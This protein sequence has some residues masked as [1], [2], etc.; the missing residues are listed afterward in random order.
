MSLRTRMN[1]FTGWVN[2]RLNKYDMLLKNVLMDLLG[3]TNMKML[4]QSMTGIDNKKLQ[5]FDG[6]THQ[7]KAT[8]MEW[9]V[10]ELK[11]NEVLPGDI[12]VDFRL[13]AMRHAEHVFDLLWRLVSHDVWFTWERLEYLTHHEDKIL[14]EVPF[15]WTPKP[16]PEKKKKKKVSYNKSF[17]SGFGGASLISDGL[18]DSPNPFETPPESL[19]STA[20]TTPTPSPNL[21]PS[22][23]TTLPS[24]L[25]P[26]LP[27]SPTPTLPPS[28]TP[29]LPPY[30]PSSA[31]SVRSF[32]EPESPPP[33][34]IKHIRFPGE[35]FCRK[36]KKKSQHR[37][38]PEEC[39]L[40]MVTTMLNSTREGRKLNVEGLDDLVDS[41]V[42]CELV[43]SFVPGTFT[44][45]VLLNDRWTINLALKTFEKMIRI[46]TPIDSSDLLEADPMAVCC[47]MGV[48]FMCGFKIRQAKGVINRLIELEHQTRAAHH[49]LDNLPEILED[50]ELIKK[51]KMLK[52]TLEDCNQERVLIESK[53]DVE[54]CRQ[55]WKHIETVQ[56][57]TR[58][59]I[60]KKMTD[61]FDLMTLP[62]A[63]SMNDLCISLAINLTLTQGSGFYLGKT[64]E[65]VTTD[66]RIVLKDAETGDFIDDFTHGKGPSKINVRKILGMSLYEPSELNPSNYPQYEIYVESP[67]K[68]KLLKAGSIFLY[69]VFPGNYLQWENL[70]FKACKVGEYDTV[71]KLIVFFQEKKPNFINAREKKTGNMGLHMAARNGHY[72]IALFLLENGAKLDARNVSG[73]SP[74]FGAVEGLHKG[75]SQMFRI[76]DGSGKNS[77]AQEGKNSHGNTA[78]LLLE[79]GAN[80]WMKNKLGKT[81]F[82]ISKND[83]QRTELVGYYDHL[84]SCIPRLMRGDVAH[85]RRLVEDHF[86]GVQKFASLRSR[87]INGSTLIHTASYFGVVAVLKVLLKERVDVNL[88]DYKGA[89][90]LHRAK[91]KPTI[92]LLL[93]NGALL[94]A[95]DGEGN[96]PLHVKCYGEGGQPTQMDCIQQFLSENINLVHRNNKELMAIH[97]C[98]M[99]GRIDAI[100]VLLDL[101]ATKDGAIRAS[102]ENEDP[103]S[104]PSLPHLAL[105]NDFLECGEWLID[106]GFTF[107]EHEQDILVHRLLTEQ[108]KSKQRLDIMR[109][110][111]KHGADLDQ[112]YAGG[113]TPVHYAAGMTG[114]T[115]ILELLIEYGADLDSVNE[116]NCTPLFFATQS[117][118]Y[119]AASVLLNGGG[120]VRHKN[121]Q[122]LTAFDCII[123][124]DEWLECGFFTDEVK[125]RL[126]AHSLKHARDLVRAITQKVRG[127]HRKG[128]FAQVAQRSNAPNPGGENRQHSLSASLPIR[129]ALKGGGNA[130]NSNMK[131]GQGMILPPL[132]PRTFMKH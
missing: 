56:T 41:R 84:Q 80:I 101:D 67:S 71:Y 68:N 12:F 54:A 103:K 60:S 30:T 11:E 110:L 66:R 44:T 19:L 117:N 45:E 70:F 17:L 59:V 24:S 91:D 78:Q 26:T 9:I 64:R 90:P 63:V 81:A 16:P 3:G 47:A 65:T 18:P 38:D 51:R 112:R 40:E 95:I 53:F 75:I 116:D 132:K 13:F 61:R 128:L 118:N 97:C 127:S 55:W 48:Y 50:V 5:S 96:T 89:T 23:T 31:G 2:L 32:G 21:P 93:E 121:I 86:A 123:D 113:N 37:P 114:P 73:A 42:L 52:E 69:Q 129:G 131:L 39:I 83:E 98:A 25:T 49:D 8:R 82:D 85:L 126:K 14:C 108:I 107:K 130:S 106:Q 35:D 74:F 77:F 27:P 46:S 1:G 22:P 87:C 57:E 4:L 125:A 76:S 33:P 6:L 36:F 100:Q 115:D 92:R 15:E 72:D 124:F 58:E 102:L 111:F 104:P 28:P 120:N 94:N 29:T 34:E 10:K 99:Q 88:R 43:N 105:A 79:W 7:Q 62:R 119:F 20:P 122:G 109:F